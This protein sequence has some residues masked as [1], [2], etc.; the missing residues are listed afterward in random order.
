MDKTGGSLCYSP[1]RD[2]KLILTSMILH[3]FCIDRGVQIDIENIESDMSY[4]ET[5]N[6]EHSDNRT[7]VRNNVG[8]AMIDS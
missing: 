5:D 7:L 8:P 3:N 6:T 4:T 1:E 2:C